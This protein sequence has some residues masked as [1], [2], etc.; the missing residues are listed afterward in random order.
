MGTKTWFLVACTAIGALG[1]SGCGGCAGSRGHIAETKADTR[2]VTEPATL[3]VGS[4]TGIEKIGLDGSERAMIFPRTKESGWTV[5]DVSPDFAWFLL[6]TSNTELFIGE[7]ATGAVRFVPAPGRRVSTARFSPDG[8]RIAAARHSDF[9]KPG[10]KPDDTIYVIDAATLA[11]ETITPATDHWPGAIRWAKDGSALWVTMNWDA[12]PQ[13]ITLADKVRRSGLTAPPAPIDQGRRPPPASC[14]ERPIAERWDPTLRLV[15]TDAGAE[16][17]RDA[18]AGHVIVELR[19]RKRGF[20]DYL[21]DFN[22]P[23][24]SPG[25]KFVVFGFENGVWVADARGGAAAPL[26]K[27]ASALFFAPAPP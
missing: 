8:K 19:G 15:D 5:F 21:P 22:D 23:V 1:G 27:D 16:A 13:W 4:A 17:E 25:C 24:M 2:F 6:E 12:G 10:A 26:V 11:T 18:S 3:F 20:H 7:V 9:D 14:P